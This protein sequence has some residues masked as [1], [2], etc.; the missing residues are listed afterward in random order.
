VLVPVS[1]LLIVFA[2]RGF[3][4]EWHVEV[5]E[6]TGPSEPGHGVGSPAAAH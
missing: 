1:L 6:S 2:M 4:Q 3:S 5:E